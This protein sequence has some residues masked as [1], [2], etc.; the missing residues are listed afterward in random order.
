MYRHQGTENVLVEARRCF[1]KEHG[2]RRNTCATQRSRTKA[3]TTRGELV[4]DAG[5]DR[6]ADHVKQW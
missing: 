1:G 6:R 3:N 5:T 2:G 4:D